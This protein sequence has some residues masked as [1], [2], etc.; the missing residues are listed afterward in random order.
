LSNP[1]T[2][3][4]TILVAAALVAAPLTAQPV[5]ATDRQQPAAAQ[6]P[7]AGQQA[8]QGTPQRGGEGRGQG[9][10]QGRGGGGPLGAAPLTFEDRTGF[11][12][13]FDG[14]SMKNWDGDPTYWKAENGALVGTSTEANAVK[15]NTFVIWRGGRPADFELKLEYRMSSTNSGIQF[16]STHLPQGSKAGDD[17]IAG[18]WVLKGYQADID[19]DNRFTGMIYEER[20]RGFL[21]QRGQAVEIGPD[22]VSRLIG[23][24]ERNADELKALIKVRDWNTV[25]LIAR[26]N[27]IMNI[28]NGHVTAFIVDDDA[29]G[30]TLRGLLGFQIHVGP[31][32]KIEFRNIYLK[33]VK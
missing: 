8:P 33:T 5:R 22:G 29:K 16:R 31:P 6:Q 13:I 1:G 4:R 18:K 28:V 19:F 20:G 12:Q 21:M 15:E 3:G 25:H 23:N 11:Q 17:T 30:R 27:T 26:G 24:L 7:P 14:V 32:M 2:F 10:G 9:R